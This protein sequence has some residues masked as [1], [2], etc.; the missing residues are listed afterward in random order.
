MDVLEE[1]EG[2]EGGGVEQRIVV[3][4]YYNDVP[5]TVE[6]FRRLLMPPPPPR[7]ESP[8]NIWGMQTPLFQEG[9]GGEGEGEEEEP[10]TYVGSVFH[11]IVPG[12]CA[13]AGGD[14]ED[15]PLYTEDIYEEK[16]VHVH[17]LGT[18]S[19]VERGKPDFFICLCTEEAPWLDEHKQHVVFGKV[20]EGLDTILK[21]TPNSVVTIVDAG[22]VD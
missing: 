17:S 4:L 16:G 10:P 21:W 18:L 1:E 3:E 6:N 22:T 13:I 20:V 5:H 8:P 14:V 7:Y 19:T 2:K 11:R 15:D 9:R 12:L